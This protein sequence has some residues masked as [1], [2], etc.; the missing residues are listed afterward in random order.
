MDVLLSNVHI[1]IAFHCECPQVK[2]LI[3]TQKILHDLL[4]FLP[5]EDNLQTHCNADLSVLQELILLFC[6]LF[7]SR[8]LI[9]S[10]IPSS[11]SWWYNGCSF[12]IILC[13]CCSVTQLCLTLCDPMG[14]SKP[15][16]SVFH[17]L[18]KFTQIHV[19][20]VVMLS[21]HL[22]LC[23]PLLLFPS[24]F[25]SIRVSSHELAPRIRWPNYLS[26]SFSISP[27]S[28]YSG[29]ISLR[30]DSPCS[31]RDSQE[32][33]PAWYFKSINSLV[34]SLPYNPTLTSVHDYWKN[35]TFDYMDLCQQNDVSAF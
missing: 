27:S 2:F 21:N 29:L 6:S 11:Y 8:F 7:L 13:C 4:L 5:L 34:I 26:F 17:Y 14:C 3:I 1:L 16:A 24:I 32:S 23:C 30:I 15:G 9:L 35:H 12:F 25:P 33:L 19:Y 18:L 28:E 22:S 10:K 20:W 31:P